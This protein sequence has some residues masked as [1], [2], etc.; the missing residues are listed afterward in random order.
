[1]RVPHLRGPLTGAA[2]AVAVVLTVVTLP[3]GLWWILLVT[4]FGLGLLLR[5]RWAWLGALLTG[6][7]GWGIPLFWQ[8]RDTP[9]GSVADVLGGLLGVPAAAAVVLTLLVAVLLALAGAWVGIAA[10]RLVSPK[11]VQA[12]PPPSSTSDGS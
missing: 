6:G 12:M 10:R 9:V 2:V 11:P 1:M 7:L 3:A 4:G 8:A 5:G